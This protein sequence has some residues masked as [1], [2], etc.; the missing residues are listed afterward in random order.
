MK[1]G[2]V[3][4]GGGTRGAY[5]VG[6]MKAMGELGIGISAVCGTSIG[7]INGAF[8]VQNDLPTL[9]ETW[10]TIRLSDVINHSQ[11]TEETNILSMSNLS[12]IIRRIRD[13]GFDISPLEKMLES[14][15]DEE[16]IRTSPVD[17]G[18]VSLSLTNKKGVR[19]F[20]SEIKKGELCKYLIASASLPVFK[21]HE[22]NN[23]QFIDGGVID[24]MPINMLIEKG[25]TDII[26]VDVRGIG[27]KRSICGAGVN[28]IEINCKEPETGILDF[29]PKGIANSIDAGYYDCKKIFGEYMGEI[30]YFR[31]DEYIAQKHRYG[32]RILSGIERAAQIFGIERLCV[33]G[34]EEFV[35]KTV[36]EYEK[37][38]VSFEKNSANT[39]ASVA[40][41]LQLIK[42]IREQKSG[43]IKNKLDIFGKYYNAAGAL[44]YFARKF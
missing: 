2:L 20:K 22:I 9:E 15:I 3:L 32:E 31:T 10:R 33:Y 27:V 8:Y 28:L 41:V 36:N 34:F 43:F 17:F 24:N 19:L 12:E 44:I 1:Y 21:K 4:A 6:V 30:Y 29:D 5:Q 11:A 37:Q 18:L 39:S 42:T 35:Q 23:E 38:L 7:A 14:L 13:D 25:Y 26:T 40:A 16:K